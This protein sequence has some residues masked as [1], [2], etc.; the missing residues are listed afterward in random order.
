M[1]GTVGAS[2]VPGEGSRFW[3]SARLPK[4]QGVM[5][6]DAPADEA[7]MEARLRAVAAGQQ[8]L[9]VEDEFINRSIALE[10]LSACGLSADTAEDGGDAVDMAAAKRYDLILMDMQMPTM[11][12]LEA[13]RRIR[14]LP[15]MASVPVVAMTANAFAEDRQQCFSAGILCNAKNE[16]FWGK[17][18]REHSW[19]FPQGDGGQLGA[20][21]GLH[22]AGRD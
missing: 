13:T 5:E 11:D 14:Q 6:M 4:A 21:A 17:R 2:S 7:G 19:Q 10:L 9:V 3:F 16:V 20:L 22:C 8:V 15:G 12:G 18:I 1:G